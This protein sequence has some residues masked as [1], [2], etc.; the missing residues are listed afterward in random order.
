MK[1]VVAEASTIAKAIE[2]AWQKAGQPKEFLIKVFQEPQRNMFGLTKTSAKVGIFFDDAAMVQKI[3][4]ATQST[5]PMAHNNT[6]KPVT[7]NPASKQISPIKPLN[8]NANPKPQAPRQPRPAPKPQPAAV[9]PVP[10]VQPAQPVL[11]QSA[12][13]QV[14]EQITQPINPE[15]INQNQITNNPVANNQAANPAGQPRTTPRKKY[16]HRRKPRAPRPNGDGSG[17][18]SAPAAPVNKSEN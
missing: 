12:L 15:N 1:S 13:N 9:N 6:S 10:V 5:I 18:A 7:S 8:K 4:N 14:A 17:Q 3:K 16:Y 2:L 11:N